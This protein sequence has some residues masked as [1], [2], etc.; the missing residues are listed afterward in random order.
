MTIKALTGLVPEWFT[1]DGEKEDSDP[2]EFL[3]RP[4]N[5]PVIAKLQSNFNSETG[6]ISGKGLYEAAVAGV[7]DWKNVV[8]HE[9]KLLKYSRR[10]LD[11]LPYELLLELGG[12]ILANSFLTEDDEKNS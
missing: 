5:A 8:N 11:S 2:A 12:Q 4:L 10:N 6:G 3:I 9:G 7:T 1:P